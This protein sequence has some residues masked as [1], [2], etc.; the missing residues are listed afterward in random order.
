MTVL[1]SDGSASD[2]RGRRAHG[3]TKPLG[4]RRRD[5]R[6]PRRATGIPGWRV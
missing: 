6:R 2:K 4:R 3:A 5:H 1:V